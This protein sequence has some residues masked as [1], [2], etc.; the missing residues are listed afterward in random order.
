[1]IKLNELFKR[2]KVMHEIGDRVSH[3]ESQKYGWVSGVSTF[4]TPSGFIMPLVSVRFENGTTATMLP[5][6]EFINLSRSG[7][8]D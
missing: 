5:A 2:T 3:R 1:M 7:V 6:N 8:K 4:K